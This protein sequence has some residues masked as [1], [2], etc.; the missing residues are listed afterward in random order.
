MP[1]LSE[2]VAIPIANRIITRFITTCVKAG[3]A[4]RP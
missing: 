3:T 4:K 2:C 1:G